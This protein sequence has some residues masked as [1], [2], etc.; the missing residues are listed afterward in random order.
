M[1][2][3]ASRA[4]QP[5]SEPTTQLKLPIFL[6]QKYEFMNEDS[7]LSDQDLFI[8]LCSAESCIEINIPNIHCSSVTS[9]LSPALRTEERPG[10]P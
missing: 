2:A 1:K 9:R 5:Q 4:P 8:Y 10:Q 7:F 3:G 6:L